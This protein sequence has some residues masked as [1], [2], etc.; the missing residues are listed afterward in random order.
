MIGE[1]Q[2]YFKPIGDDAWM[3]YHHHYYYQS[4]TTK[5]SSQQQHQKDRVR[6]RERESQKAKNLAKR[7][8]HGSFFQKEGSSAK[9]KNLSKRF[10]YG[11]FFSLNNN[12]TGTL[13]ILLGKKGSHP[14]F[15]D[16]PKKAFG[17]LHLVPHLSTVR[18]TF[19]YIPCFSF[20]TV[21]GNCFFV[22]LV[23]IFQPLHSIPLL[24]VFQQHV[25]TTGSYPGTGRRRGHT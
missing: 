11:S 9:K 23:F 20:I 4:Q 17:T 10:C 21:Q 25:D 19:I 8:C 1:K 22:S 24:P 3:Y 14:T 16:D 13:Y 7:F 15:Y 12:I 2:G 5:S 18:V 6:E